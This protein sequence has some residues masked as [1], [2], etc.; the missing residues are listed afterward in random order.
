MAEGTDAEAIVLG[1]GPAGMVAAT[2]L[3]TDG[4]RVCLVDGLPG[5]GRTMVMDTVHDLPAAEDDLTGP[6]LASRLLDRMLDAG[7]DL[8]AMHAQAVTPAPTPAA[9][10]HTVQLDEGLMTAATVV[11][12]TGTTEGRLG[13]P[14]EDAWIGRGISHCATCDAPL[15]AGDPVMV[16][17]DG[18]W[19]AEEALTLAKYASQVVL[20]VP[21]VALTCAPSRHQRLAACDNVTVV[22]GTRVVSLGDGADDRLVSVGLEGADVGEVRVRAVVPLVGRAP[23]TEMMELGLARRP[24]GALSTVRGATNVAGVFAAGDVCGPPFQTVNSALTDALLAAREVSR[25]LADRH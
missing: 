6:A 5:G 22:A 21:E 14:D 9:A 1:G 3:A 15:F 17:G 23:N 18:D 2:M 20:V 12:A 25:Y 13:V 19:A 7:V 16:V 8:V 10:L 24:D 4:W 11:V